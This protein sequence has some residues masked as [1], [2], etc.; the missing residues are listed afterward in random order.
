MHDPPPILILNNEILEE[1]IC[2][3]FLG[4]MLDRNL[5]FQEHINYVTEKLSKYVPIMYQIRH[6]MPAKALRT[7]Y[8]TLI[9]P[10]L[11]YCNSIW[12]SVYA[13]NLKPL[14]VIQ[15]RIIK[16]MYFKPIR[17]PSAELFVSKFLLSV[18]QI[19]KYTCCLYVFKSMHSSSNIFSFQTNIYN[20]RTSNANIVSLPG[21]FTT[22]SR[23]SARWVGAREWNGLPDDV[24][25][26]H[27]STSTFK[28]KVKR[29]LVNSNN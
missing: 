26:L 1:K 24:R 16:A 2:T 3:K 20:T 9:L 25:H 6:N 13:S 22:H 15:K 4:L 23:Q 29:Y 27:Q 11:C 7:I 18:E 19:N 10:C 12:G 17:Y 14:Q 5:C 8:N 21:I 28:Y